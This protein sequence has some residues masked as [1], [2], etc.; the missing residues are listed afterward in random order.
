ML[1]LKLMLMIFTNWLYD[2]KILIFLERQKSVMYLKFLNQKNTGLLS[3]YQKISLNRKKNALM[4]PE[5]ILKRK[6]A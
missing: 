2:Q 6:L 5:V 1:P 3:S 4:F